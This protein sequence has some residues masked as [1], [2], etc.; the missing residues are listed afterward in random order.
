MKATCPTAD[1]VF[2][3]S[4]TAD[5]YN[6]HKIFLCISM[7]F[8]NIEVPKMYKIINCAE[9]YSGLRRTERVQR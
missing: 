7:L 6:T 4:T 3:N 8:L 9:Q 5:A 1:K 2:E